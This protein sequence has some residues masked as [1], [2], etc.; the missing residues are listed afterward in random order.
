MIFYILAGV[1]SAIG[2]LFMLFKLDIKKVLAF[3]VFVDIG[4]SLLL[5]VMFAGTFAGMMAAVIAGSIISIALFCMKK[6]IGCKKPR[7]NG[8]RWQWV[9]VPPT[10]A[11]HATYQ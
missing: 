11:H 5:I 4:A 1:A 10:T 6:L 7:R 9:N 8:L 3:D 2:V